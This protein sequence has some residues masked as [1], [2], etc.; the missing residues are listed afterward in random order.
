MPWKSLELGCYDYISDARDVDS[1]VSD[2]QEFWHLFVDDIITS[3]NPET[4]NY[5][6][7]DV[8]PADGGIGVYPQ[9]TESGVFR[10]S[11]GSL[12]IV[13][14]FDEIMAL[15]DDD[16]WASGQHEITMKYLQIVFHAARNINLATR[17]GRK[18][19]VLLRAFLYIEDKKPPLLEE[20]VHPDE[21]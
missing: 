11:W 17:S 15:P 7:L 5:L 13:S 10:V 2:V 14:F 21:I 20:I 19:G 6:L 9:H 16:A 4:W 12:G 1:L 8:R 18:E 3:I